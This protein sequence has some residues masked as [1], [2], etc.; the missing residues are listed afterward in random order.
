MFG[1]PEKTTYFPANYIELFG[2]GTKPVDWRGDVPDLDELI[3]QLKDQLI[4]HQQIPVEQLS[5]K[6]KQPFMGLGTFG[7]L[8]GMAVWHEANHLGHIQ[9]MKRIVENKSIKN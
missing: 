7:E 4:Q 1:F 5:E 2:N 6:I 8:V 3:V 9:A